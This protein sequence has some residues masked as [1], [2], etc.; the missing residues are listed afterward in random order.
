MD[1]ISK[2]YVFMAFLF[3]LYMITVVSLCENPSKYVEGGNSTCKICKICI[4]LVDIVKY[5]IKMTNNTITIIDKILNDICKTIIIKQERYECEEIV[6]DMY[7]ITEW[8]INGTYTLDICKKL[9][10]CK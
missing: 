3:V 6:E 9:G 2:F 4:D 1:I 7:N 10:F 5:E 8:I